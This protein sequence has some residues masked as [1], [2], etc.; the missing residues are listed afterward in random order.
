M[1]LGAADSPIRRD[2]ASA[3][4]IFCPQR[5]GFDVRPRPTMQWNETYERLVTN[6]FLLNSAHAG[7]QRISYIR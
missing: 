7:N 5:C 1:N 4:L 3:L 6:A 2:D